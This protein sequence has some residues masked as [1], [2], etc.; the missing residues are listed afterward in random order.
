MNTQNQTTMET[1]TIEEI[2]QMELSRIRNHYVSGLAA[3]SNFASLNLDTICDRILESEKELQEEVFNYLEKLLTLEAR[4][5][6]FTLEDVLIIMKNQYLTNN[7]FALKC[8]AITLRYTSLL[9]AEKNL[10]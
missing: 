8:N 10:W 2:Q 9:E 6:G 3:Y 1:V 7:D 5:L 4:D